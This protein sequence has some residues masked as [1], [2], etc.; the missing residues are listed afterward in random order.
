VPTV[1]VRAAYEKYYCGRLGLPPESHVDCMSFG[2]GNKTHYYF[3]LPRTIACHHGTTK[4]NS[5]IDTKLQ[6]YV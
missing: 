3:T 2:G 6:L 1:G 4:I 5:R